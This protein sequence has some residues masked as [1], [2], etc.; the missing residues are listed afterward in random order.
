MKQFKTLK[1]YLTEDLD[2]ELC[3]SCNNYSKP[4]NEPPCSN[5][6]MTVSNFQPLKQSEKSEVPK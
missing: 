1:V 6:T 4:N 3:D 5:C 2:N